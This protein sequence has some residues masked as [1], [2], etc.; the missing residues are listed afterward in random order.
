[1]S[2]LILKVALL[3]DFQSV[4]F[5]EIIVHEHNF[6]KVRRKIESELL[7]I[8]KVLNQY[9]KDG[10]IKS[11]SRPK[12]KKITEKLKQIN[13]ARKDLTDSKEKIMQIFYK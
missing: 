12:N 9:K 8:K 4:E 1:M 5:M 7:K 13:H 3:D 10:L 11:I 2:K 6:E